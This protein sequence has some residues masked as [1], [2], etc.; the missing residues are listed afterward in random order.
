MCKNIVPN[1]KSG[2]RVDTIMPYMKNLLC[3]DK[4]QFSLHYKLY[5]WEGQIIKH[6]WVSLHS[7][8]S[9]FHIYL[10]HVSVYPN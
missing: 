8:Q 5:I 4:N 2:D 1:S 7:F 6:I 10:F 9:M 3:M